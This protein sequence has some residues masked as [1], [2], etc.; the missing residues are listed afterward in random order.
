M[1]RNLVKAFTLPQ[2]ILA[3]AT[4]CLLLSSCTTS[5]EKTASNVR[6]G[7]P[8]YYTYNSG[9]REFQARWPFGPGGYH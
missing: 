1:K 8:S 6:S 3:T 4:L 5:G 9:A 7:N 2:L